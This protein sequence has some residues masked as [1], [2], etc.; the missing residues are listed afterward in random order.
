MSSGRGGGAGSGGRV[1][2]KKRNF[3]LYILPALF[4]SLFKDDYFFGLCS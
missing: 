1:M 3:K 2:E 4:P